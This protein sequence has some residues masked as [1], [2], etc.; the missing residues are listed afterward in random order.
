M[1]HEISEIEGFSRSPKL[2]STC[3]SLESFNVYIGTVSTVCITSIV[4]L[5]ECVRGS[6][7]VL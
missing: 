3:E 4:L 2:L 1:C 5:A 7:R 6:A